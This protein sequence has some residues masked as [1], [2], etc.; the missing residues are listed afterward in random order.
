MAQCGA[1]T[2]TGGICKQPALQNGRCHYH[3]GKSLAGIASGTYRTGRYSK[4]LPA[5]LAGRYEEARQD[6]ALLELRDEIGLVDSRLSDL[7]GRVDTGESGAI[8]RALKAA[9][10]DLLKARNDPIK[11]AI[12]LN[13]MGELI[14]RGHADY[15]AWNEIAAVLEQ[16]RRLVESERKRLI[17][18]QQTITTNQAMVLVTALLSSI[19][20]HVTDR[21]ALAKIQND[22]IRLTTQ[23]PS[24]GII[25]V[26]PDE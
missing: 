22:F 25:D 13:A 23:E 18:L 7:L 6:A 11:A 20:E 9:H 15:A 8:W 4:V 19:K 12:A 2:R 17:E 26:T 5:R 14:T 21:Q 24:P 16:R 10:L 3:G 1:K